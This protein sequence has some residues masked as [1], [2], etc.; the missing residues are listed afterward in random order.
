MVKTLGLWVACLT[1]VAMVGAVGQ[2][3]KGDKR[4][5]QGDKIEVRQLNLT[6]VRLN[7]RE[8]ER[9]RVDMAVVITDAEGLADAFPD[10]NSQQA[11]AAQVDF[12]KEKLLFFRWAGSGGDRI[13]PQVQRANGNVR[14]VFKY[15][16]GLTHDLHG[17]HYLFAVPR[18][19]RWEVE[20]EKQ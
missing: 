16:R 7:P 9:S 14:V 11:I 17:H 12:R 19:V 13:R 4:E 5:G 1:G 3:G 15:Q 2:D 18:G 6:G 20:Q 10:E 8:A